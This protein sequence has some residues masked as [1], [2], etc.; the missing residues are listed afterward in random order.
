[1]FI[2]YLTIML[3]NLGA[4]LVLLAFFVFRLNNMDNA[5]KRRWVPGFTITGFTGLVTGIHMIF[6]WPL[7]GSFNI[8]FG[9]MSVLFSILFLGAALALAKDYQL[10]SVTIYALFAGGAALVVGIRIINLGLT[11]EPAMSGAGFILTGIGGILS[12]PT[13]LLRNKK[14]VALLCGAV[15]LIAA[16]IW[17]ITVYGSYWGHLESFKD[18]KPVH[19]R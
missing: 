19:M 11:K 4:G 10:L 12:T 13:Y 2:D 6:T 17:F 15:L 9:E 18:W 1:M 5:E 16:V 8:A 3:L 14:G 7:P